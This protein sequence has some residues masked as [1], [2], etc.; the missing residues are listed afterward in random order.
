MSVYLVFL[1][2]RPFIVNCLSFDRRQSKIQHNQ[3]FRPDY[4]KK[5]QLIRLCHIAYSKPIKRRR[6]SSV[7]IH[8]VEIKDYLDRKIVCQ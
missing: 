1:A 4:F 6:S 7:R 2:V 8:N 5:Q 3:L